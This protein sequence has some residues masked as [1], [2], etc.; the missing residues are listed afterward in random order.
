MFVGSASAAGCRRSCWLASASTQPE[1]AVC[2]S[3][4]LLRVTPPEKTLEQIEKDLH[5]TSD[6][7]LLKEGAFIPHQ[8]LRQLQAAR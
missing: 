8:L 7:D 4:A 1:L 5:R 3:Q 6:H 2:L